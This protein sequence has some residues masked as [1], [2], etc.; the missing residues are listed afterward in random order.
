VS[1]VLD[2][3]FA[4]DVVTRMGGRLKSV[5]FRKARPTT[6]N[7][8]DPSNIAPTFDTYAADGIAFRYEVGFVSDQIVDGDYRVVILR[9]SIK[10]GSVV[11]D[12]VLPDPGDTVDCPP[13]GQ[14]TAKRAT[15]IAVE[16][17][18][19]AQITVQVRGPKAG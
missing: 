14:D 16:V 8:S 17:L 9:G 4:A 6:V 7:P 13:P 5:T 11:V 10:L 15:V 2:R 1:S 18:T 12:T 3:D 19:E